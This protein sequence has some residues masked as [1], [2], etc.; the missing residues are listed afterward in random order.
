VVFFRNFAAGDVEL[1]KALL[2]CGRQMSLRGNNRGADVW[3]NF[4]LKLARPF[5]THATFLSIT[6]P[7][8]R[9]IP[10][11]VASPGAC[12]G[13]GAAHFRVPWC[14]ARRSALLPL[15]G[16]PIVRMNSSLIGRIHVECEY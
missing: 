7:F 6:P 8:V 12:R 2:I 13:I 1:A 16:S 14:M 11:E 3:K 15:A 10:H 5:S 9:A 4:R